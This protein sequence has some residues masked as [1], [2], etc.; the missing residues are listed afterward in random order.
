MFTTSAT[1]TLANNVE[2]LT[3]TGAGNFA[4]NGNVSANTYI[5]GGAGNDTLTATANDTNGGRQRHARSAA[6]AT[7]P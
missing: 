4:G 1:F 3:F 7:T 2:N 5:T 6:P